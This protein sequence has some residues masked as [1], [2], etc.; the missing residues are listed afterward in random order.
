MLKLAI[1]RQRYT[2]FGGAERFVE[3]ALAAL[4]GQGT[5]ATVICRDWQGSET[6][7]SHVLRCDP[8]YRRGLDRRTARDRSFA[9]GVQQ[10]LRQQHFDIVQSH[11]RIPGAMIYRAGDGVHAA[12]LDHLRRAR[13]PLGRL[14]LALSPYH[15]Y[16]LATERAM[17]A[18]PALRAVICNSR[19]VR[20][21]LRR[22]YA[23]PEDKL[24]L[25]PNG[26]D[27]ERFS[28]AAVRP[29]RA[30]KRAALGLQD[31][32]FAWVLVGN[33]FE[34]KGVF[35]L[36]RALAMTG[37]PRQHLLVVGGDRQLR[38]AQQLAGRLGLAPRVHWLGEQQDVRPW[39]GAADAFALPTL[40]DPCPNAALE[41]LASG[42][43]VLTS[44]SC[45]AAEYLAPGQNGEVCD[46]LDLAGMAAAM[47]RMIS[48]ASPD[49]PCPAAR[50]AVAGLGLPELA[51]R[52]QA[53]YRSLLPA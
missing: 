13:S 47:R 19:L 27:L 14:G 20:D 45:G 10:L 7:A 53:L 18:H 34:R 2:P 3:R 24:V 5:Q 32:D 46:A 52:L 50:A 25:I 39:L 28:P 43:P 1:I 16:L 41:A 31:E 49:Q 48:A 29:F 51:L 33:G 37:D 22:Y 21:E 9:Q 6:A 35:R 23:V 11:E 8:P 15:R 36:L 4:D 17:F 40:Y 12:W 44:T 26:I 30:E 38:A 42:L